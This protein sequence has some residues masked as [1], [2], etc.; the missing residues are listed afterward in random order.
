VAFYDIYVSDDGGPFKPNRLRIKVTSGRFTRE[1]GHT[2][3]FYSIATDHVGNWEATSAAAQGMTT[4][5]TFPY[6]SVVLSVGSVP[7]G[8][9][10]SITVTAYDVNNNVI[11]DYAGTVRF[12][13]SDSRAVLPD[14]YTFTAADAGVHT[15]DGVVLFRAGNQSVIVNDV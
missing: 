12:N 13:S 3:G 14:D 5:V 11:A 9:P 1:S 4:I 10:F 7:A 6:L 8:I 15:F 2:Y